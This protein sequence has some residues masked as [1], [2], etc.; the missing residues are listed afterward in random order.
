MFPQL[1][2]L[3][4]MD[5]KLVTYLDI[6]LALLQTCLVPIGADLLNP[7]MIL[8]NRPISGLLPQMKRTPLM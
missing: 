6:H 5:T 2:V 7:A 3:S 8:L 4:N 1:V